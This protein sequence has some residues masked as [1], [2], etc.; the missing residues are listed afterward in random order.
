MLKMIHE[1][2]KITYIQTGVDLDIRCML[3]NMHK[4]AAPSGLPSGYF[5]GT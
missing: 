1:R 5:I 3:G 4:M 2:L